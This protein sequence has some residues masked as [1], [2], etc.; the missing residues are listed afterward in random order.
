MHDTRRETAEIG[1]VANDTWARCCTTAS[2]R[3]GRFRVMHEAPIGESQGRMG[4]GNRGRGRAH[5][6]SSRTENEVI[7]TRPGWASS[8]MGSRPG[9]GDGPCC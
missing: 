5:D 1:S 9:V 2:L 4:I 7:L 3:A 8:A 6:E